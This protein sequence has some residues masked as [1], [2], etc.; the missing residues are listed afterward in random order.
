MINIV[1]GGDT[2]P[3][4]RNLAAFR[5]GQ[6]A[7]LFKDLV[8]EFTAADYSVV[9]LECPLIDAP[10]PIAKSGPVLGVDA[11]CAATLRNAGICAV[12]L[13]NNHIMDHGPQGLRRTIRACA[14]A[15]LEVV[16]AGENLVAAGQPLIKEIAGMRVAFLGMAERE[17]CIAGHDAP[18]ANPLDMI[19]FRRLVRKRQRDYDHLIVLLHGGKEYYPYPSPRLQKTCRFLVEEGASAVV[20]QHSH[21]AGTF[22]VYRNAAIVYGQGNLLF[23]LN[24]DEEG[25]WDGFL[26]KLTLEK[27]VPGARLQFIPHTQ[28]R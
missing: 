7:S 19:D 10:S 25:W 26:V 16:G 2:C 24:I 14:D 18:G 11:C 23:D 12:N 8:P 3:I 15:G 1:I 17:F 22:E 4:N 6:A 28:A 13:A 21:C 9:N 27:D 20:C 5:R